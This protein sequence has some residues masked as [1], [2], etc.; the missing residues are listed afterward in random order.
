MRAICL[1]AAVIGAVLAFGSGRA[2]GAIRD[3]LECHKVKDTLKLPAGTTADL[4]ADL[5]P[6]FTAN[7]CRVVKPKLLCSPIR[8]ENVQPSP[9]LSIAG[10]VLNDYYICYSIKCAVRPPDKTFFDQFGTHQLTKIKPN[11]LCVPAQPAGPVATTTATATTTTTTL[12]GCCSA[13]RIVLAGTGG[14]HK[15]S[16]L[17][18]TPVPAGASLIIDANPPSLFP[19]CQHLATVP[20]GG[21]SI[22]PLCLVGLNF[23]ASITPNGCAAGADHGT[24]VVWDGGAACPTPQISKS[25]DSSDGVCN[26]PGQ[27]CTTSAGGAGA[28][29]LG[30]VDGTPGGPCVA[31]GLHALVEIP[32]HERWW[33]PPSAAC[34]DPDGTF[35]PGTDTLIMDG[36][37]IM[38]LSSDVATA[39]FADE[40]GDACSGAGSGPMGPVSETGAPA[41]GPCCV[42][43]QT[44]TLVSGNPVFTG[45]PPLF[46]MIG[47]N[48]LQFSVS[49]CNSFPG[50]GSCTL[51]NS[52]MD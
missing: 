49:Q 43:G 4:V 7:G 26:P 1:T 9:P 2:E 13:Q 15:T 46:D 12:L 16:T 30:D 25:A 38:S 23:T 11:L 18:P 51:P 48:V 37:Y 5:D 22:P 40:N 45:G 42:P 20:A 31:P 36:D 50:A 39:Q 3:H 27:P 44:M 19:G 52:C 28:N 34:P 29:T 33:L 24:G 17:P 8:K 14:Q 10:Q 6:D 35:D 47:R 21:L 32:V 41:T